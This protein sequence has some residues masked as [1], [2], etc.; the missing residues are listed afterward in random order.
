MLSDKVGNLT[1]ASHHILRPVSVPVL[2]MDKHGP[3]TSSAACDNR[4]PY[5]DKSKMV[6]FFLWSTSF[7]S[8][9]LCDKEHQT[10]GAS[11]YKRHLCLSYCCERSCQLLGR[12]YAGS[13]RASHTSEPSLKSAR[14]PSTLGF[15]W[16]TSF[17]TGKNTG[18][19][20]GT[21]LVHYLKLDHRCL[22]PRPFQFCFHHHCINPYCTNWATDRV[23][24]EINAYR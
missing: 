10:I 19:L 3:L 13:T 20:P 24:T 2:S 5:Y 22:H 16:F 18:T 6:Y 8:N 1:S 14:R 23:V 4:M 15:S 7:Q 17:R 12:Y 11:P 21:I 9:P